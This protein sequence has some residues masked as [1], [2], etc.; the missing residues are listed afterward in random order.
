MVTHQHKSLNAWFQTLFYGKCL[1]LF[2]RH[3]LMYLK[4]YD[5]ESI[6]P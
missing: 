6:I 3:V 2:N 1:R 5:S 4:N